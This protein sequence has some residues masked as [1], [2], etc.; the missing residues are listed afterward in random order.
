MFA[1][2]VGNNSKKLDWI[3]IKAAGFLKS[4]VKSGWEEGR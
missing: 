1:T 3:Y 2:V 4:Q